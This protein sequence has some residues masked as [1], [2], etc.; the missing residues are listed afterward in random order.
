MGMLKQIALIRNYQAKVAQEHRNRVVQFFFN[1]YS[2]LWFYTEFFLPPDYRRPYTFIMRDFMMLHPIA[3]GFIV[4]GE[5]T[6]LVFLA[7]WNLAAGLPVWA[8]YFLVMG[9][10]I[11]GRNMILG[12]QEEPTFNP[13]DID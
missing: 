1:F 10:L 13:W 3:A 6:G 8:F 5:I 7:R 2:V 12:E 11:W 4:A 9:H